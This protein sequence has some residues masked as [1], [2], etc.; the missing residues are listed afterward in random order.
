MVN[1]KG[2]RTIWI[3]FPSLK[4]FYARNIPSYISPLSFF[5]KMTPKSHGKKNFHNRIFSWTK[6]WTSRLSVLEDIT[7]VNPSDIH[8]TFNNY[9]TYESNY[10]LT[11]LSWRI[12]GS[13]VLCQMPVNNSAYGLRSQNRDKNWHFTAPEFFARCHLITTSFSKN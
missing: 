7:R 5:E 3:W 4:S 13:G 9:S 2:S 6:L 12:F 1:C 10:I 8:F 11:L